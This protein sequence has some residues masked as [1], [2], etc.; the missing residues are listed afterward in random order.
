MNQWSVFIP[1]R[2]YIF[3]NC[4][5]HFLSFVARRGHKLICK[6]INWGFSNY[7]VIVELVVRLGGGGGFI[8]IQF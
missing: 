6:S 2:D 7:F 4:F 1:A 3:K 8:D 5:L